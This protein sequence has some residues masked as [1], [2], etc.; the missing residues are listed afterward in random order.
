MPLVRLMKRK[1]AGNCPLGIHPVQSKDRLRTA[2]A[3]PQLRTATRGHERNAAIGQWTGI[4]IV[5]GTV[6]ELAESR[7]IGVH[8]E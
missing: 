1:R 3:T 7:A 6:R 8:G 5:V 4:K 2:T